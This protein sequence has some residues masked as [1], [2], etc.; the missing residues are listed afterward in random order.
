[1]E[2]GGMRF[3]VLSPRIARICTDKH[4]NL[5]NLSVK[6]NYSKSNS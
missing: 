3:A 1:M 6:I 4:K 2:V 5:R